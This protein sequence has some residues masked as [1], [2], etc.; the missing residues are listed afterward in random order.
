M[1][2]HGHAAYGTAEAVPFRHNSTRPV[3][4]LLQP[5]D[6]VEVADGAVEAVHVR[7][8]ARCNKDGANGGAAGGIEGGDLLPHRL[9]PRGQVQPIDLCG[10][11]AGAVEENRVA[12]LA[13]VDGKNARL[14]Y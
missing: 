12:V 13:E 4:Q 1:T 8:T 7:L 11:F 10:H 5:F 2:Q 9:V 6:E 3:L 14:P